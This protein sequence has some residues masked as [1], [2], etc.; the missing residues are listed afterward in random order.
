MKFSA[1]RK[2]NNVFFIS[3]RFFGSKSCTY[4]VVYNTHGC[5][6]TSIAQIVNTLLDQ[7][8]DLL[9]VCTSP[10]AIRFSRFFLVAQQTYFIFILQ[11]VALKRKFTA[12]TR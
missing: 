2:S 4:F 12:L 5:P 10:N 1:P 11:T 8:F 6:V 7:K 9:V 3:L